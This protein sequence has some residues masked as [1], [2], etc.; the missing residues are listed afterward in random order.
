MTLCGI[1]FIALNN[2]EAELEGQDTKA[3]ANMHGSAG[4]DRTEKLWHVYDSR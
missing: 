1:K 3:D 2:S 4:A